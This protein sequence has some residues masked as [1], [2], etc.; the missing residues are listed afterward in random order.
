MKTTPVTV[1]DIKLWQD[2]TPADYS[3]WDEETIADCDG[4]L[5]ILLERADEQ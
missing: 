5:T 3:Q 2:S 1:E 4:F